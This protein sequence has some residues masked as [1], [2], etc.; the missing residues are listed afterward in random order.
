M[1]GTIN[2]AVWRR[3][4]YRSHTQVVPVYTMSDTAMG[5]MV[6]YA[7]KAQLNVLT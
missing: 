3:R 5:T 2:T 1:A 4:E 6:P 7:N